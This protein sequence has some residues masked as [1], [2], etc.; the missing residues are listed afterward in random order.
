MQSRTVL[1][2]Q[3]LR[4]RT[5]A[6]GDRVYTMLNAANRDP[7]AYLDPDRLA[8]QRDGVPQLSFGF[9]MHIC[10]GFPLARLEGQI[11]LPA[12][13]AR[14]PRIELAVPES[15]LEWQESMVFRGMRRMP[16][17]VAR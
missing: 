4:G 14:W 16:L 12:V 1:V 7:E 2:E 3:Q 6:V 10:Q 11:A 17:R 13:L 9:G 8:L 15:E 5:L